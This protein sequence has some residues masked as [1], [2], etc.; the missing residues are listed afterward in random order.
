MPTTCYTHMSVDER[1]TLILGLAQ[2]HS[3]REMATVIGLAFQHGE[4]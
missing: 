2:G 4:P 1:E 3:L